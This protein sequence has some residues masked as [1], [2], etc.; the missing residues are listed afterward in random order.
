MCEV[1][2]YACSDINNEAGCC[3]RYTPDIRSIR[4]RIMID[5]RTARYMFVETYVAVIAALW[6]SHVS[7]LATILVAF[8]IQ[9]LN[10]ISHRL[11]YRLIS[12]AHG[13]QGA[14]CRLEFIP[15]APIKR[16][17]IRN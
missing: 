16:E 10:V 3:D 4:I 7:T 1:M 12:S 17:F 5:D 14:L 2:Q 15:L 11:L 13:L 8:V 9:L 6:G